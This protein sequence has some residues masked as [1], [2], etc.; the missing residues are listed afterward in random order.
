MIK[1]TKKE[2]VLLQKEIDEICRHKVITS[3]ST[4]ILPKE[5]KI[6]FQTVLNNKDNFYTQYY[7]VK[8]DSN[9]MKILL[10]KIRTN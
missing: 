2:A 7:D 1:I 6:K 5:L 3:P 4:N 9:T 8:I 10:S